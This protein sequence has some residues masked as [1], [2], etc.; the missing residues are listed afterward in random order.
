[1][2]RTL[3]TRTMKIMVSTEESMKELEVI[4]TCK[5]TSISTQT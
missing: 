1:M 3:F 4:S 5:A 2:L